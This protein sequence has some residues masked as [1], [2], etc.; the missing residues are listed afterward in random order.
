[1]CRIFTARGNILIRQLTYSIYIVIIPKCIGPEHTN[2]KKI[3]VIFSYILI[4]IF[5]LFNPHVFVCLDSHITFYSH[6][7]KDDKMEGVFNA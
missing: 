2:N 6:I 7:P 4:A 3:K 5:A 1:M